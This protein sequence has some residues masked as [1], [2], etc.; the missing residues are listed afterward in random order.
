MLHPHSHPRRRLHSAHFH[1]ANQSQDIN[2]D[3]CA[4][5]AVLLPRSA[6]E[7]TG[8]LLRVELASFYLH[9]NPMR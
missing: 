6:K 4:F 9:N 5:L 7:S 3:L 1:S 8:E 2:P